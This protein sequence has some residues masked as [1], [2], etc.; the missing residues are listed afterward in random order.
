MPWAGRVACNNTLLHLNGARKGLAASHRLAVHLAPYVGGLAVLSAGSL[1]LQRQK[2]RQSRRQSVL[3]QGAAVVEVTTPA[4]ANLPGRASLSSSASDA[5]SQPGS[6]DET[7][8]AARDNGSAN[9]QHVRLSIGA[10][11][12]PHP[13]KVEK[14]GEDAY[15]FTEDGKFLGI[16]DGVGGWSLSNID[17]G[18]YSRMLMRTAQAAALITPPSPIAP[19]IILEEAHARTNVKGTSTACILALEDDKLHAANLGDSGF[20]VVRKQQVLFKSPS[21]QHRFNFPYQLGC[22]GTL[23]DLPEH[24]ELYTVDLS[25]GD[26]IVAATDGLFDN[27]YND[28]TAV[29]VSE[30]QRRGHAP[31]EAAS[32]VAQFARSRAGDPQHPSPFAHGATLAGW[33]NVHGGKMDDI[34]VLVAYV[35]PNSPASKL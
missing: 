7:P 13:D 11:C 29:L 23:S 20:I 28:E 17:S 30:L 27:V 16:A 32:G 34:T 3:N 21:Q 14:G 31:Q 12:L 24:A 8:A 25:A 9:D 35:L 18:V 19:Q 22:P 6:G 1:C 2:V 5:E 15:F 26:I 33:P 4:D 10:S